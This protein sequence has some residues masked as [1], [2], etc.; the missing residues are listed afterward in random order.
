MS[1]E[2]YAHEAAQAGRVTKNYNHLQGYRFLFWIPV[3]LLWWGSEAGVLAGGWWVWAFLAALVFGM[4]GSVLVGDWYGRRYG[5]VTRS[6]QS[7]ARGLVG[8]ALVIAVTA[9]AFIGVG[10]ASWG[11][12]LTTGP[13]SGIGAVAGLAWAVAWL[14]L[15]DIVPPPWWFAW[16]LAAVSLAPLGWLPGL[17]GLHPLNFPGAVFGVIAAYLGVVGLASHRALHT[18]L[19]GPPRR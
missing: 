1:S 2:H 11:S 8:A 14:R 3:V 19:G 5:R 9:L 18:R 7:L 15:R 13:V 10:S 6:H 16:A 17:D 12:A 4:V